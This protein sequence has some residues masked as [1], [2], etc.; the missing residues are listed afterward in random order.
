MVSAIT[1][2]A[3]MSGRAKAA[4]KHRHMLNMMSAIAIQAAFNM[5]D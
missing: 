4:A 5:T 1:I 3:E 2:D